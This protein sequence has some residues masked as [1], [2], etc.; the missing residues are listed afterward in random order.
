MSAPHELDPKFIA[1]VKL[2]ERTGARSFRIGH[3]DD[4]DGDPVVWYATATWSVT[5]S[6]RPGAA[7]A[8]EAAG[9]IHPVVAVM[10]L[11]D[12]VITGGQ[13]AHCH[14]PTIFDENPADTPFDAL[15]DAMGCVYAWD[16]E[17]RTFRRS[18][19]GDT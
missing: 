19:E 1:G 12:Q 16:P 6:G 2:I 10:R 8:H 7:T 9:A 5:S 17:L 3:S 18:C 15:L 14:Q 4:D 11:C 13:C